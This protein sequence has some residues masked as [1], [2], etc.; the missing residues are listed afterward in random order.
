MKHRYMRGISVLLVTGT[1]MLLASLGTFALTQGALYQIKRINMTLTSAQSYWRAEGGLECGYAYLRAAK[2]IKINSLLGE[3]CSAL[4]ADA[5][6]L[7]ELHSDQTAP[8]TL[9]ARHDYMTVKRTLDFGR[10]KAQ[11]GLRSNADIIV[12]GSLT[13][14]TVDLGLPGALKPFYQCTV[15][16]VEQ[17][18]VSGGITSQGQGVNSHGVQWCDD[19]YHTDALSESGV[20]L[21]AGTE[22]IIRR[23]KLD[24]KLEQNLSPFEDLFG[25]AREASDKVKQSSEQGFIQVAGLPNINDCYQSFADELQLGAINKVWIEGGCRLS[26]SDVERLHQIQRLEPDTLLLILVQDGVFMLDLVSDLTVVIVH[27]NQTYRTESTQWAQVGDIEAMISESLEQRF[28]RV[29]GDLSPATPLH[30][31]YIQTGNGA[32]HGGVFLDTQQQI[33]LFT[34]SPTINFDRDVLNQMQLRGA[35]QWLPASWYVE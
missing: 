16:V 2:Q 21:E 26:A 18:L 34:G 1:I 8:D 23:A 7:D 14:S 4:A 31:V 28:E 22:T 32:I 13:F 33:A 25:I 9:I 19:A 24:V 12:A 10:Y 30:A 27:L 29:F 35:A 20:W 3:S 11:S 15:A 6:A 5:L 17:R